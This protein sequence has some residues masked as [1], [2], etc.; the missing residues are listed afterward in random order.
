[1][2]LDDSSTYLLHGNLN[3]IKDRPKGGK[4]AKGPDDVLK[5]TEIA[6]VDRQVTN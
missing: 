6:I 1:M 4:R 5:L 3:E 2:T